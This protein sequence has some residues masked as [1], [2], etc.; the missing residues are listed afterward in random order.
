[1]KVKVVFSL[2][3]GLVFG[4]SS[5]V[6]GYSG[7]DGTVGD[8]Y[9]IANKTDFLELA[10]TPGDYGKFFI[11]TSDVNLDGEIF[12][13]SPIAPDTNNLDPDFQGTWFEGALD[14]QGFVIRNLTIDAPQGDYIGLIGNLNGKNIGCGLV[15]NLLLENVDVLGRDCVGGLVGNAR[16]WAA[17]IE[18]CGVSGVVEGGDNVGGLVGYKW[19]GNTSSVVINCF[20]E[21]SVSG[22]EHVG[23]LVGENENL[24]EKSYSTAS[25]GSGTYFFGGLVGSGNS[26]SVT[27]S[28]WDV[29]TSHQAASAGVQG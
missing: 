12:S 3:F 25:V 4:L 10:G 11:L 29:E 26:A 17:W 8:P 6:F 21:V 22:D 16:N 5:C 13:Q 2:V 27:R 23:G 28:F 14:G 15:K 1:M 24:I 7:G 9:Q 20:A 19:C 18:N